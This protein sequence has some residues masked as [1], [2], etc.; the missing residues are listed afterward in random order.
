M[1]RQS[2]TRG[3]EGPLHGREGRHT[4]RPSPSLGLERGSLDAHTCLETEGQLTHL[5]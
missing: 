4:C 5:S 2:W 3:S 1:A